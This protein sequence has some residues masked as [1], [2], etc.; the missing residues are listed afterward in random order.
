MLPYLNDRSEEVKL[1]AAKVLW[2]FGVMNA[3]SSLKKM[4]GSGSDSIKRKASIILALMG[5]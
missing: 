3:Y 1:S 2:K 5:I 4:L